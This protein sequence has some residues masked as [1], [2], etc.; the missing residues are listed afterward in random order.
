MSAPKSLLR[1]IGDHPAFA[2][3]E[4][5]PPFERGAS[6]IYTVRLQPGWCVGGMCEQTVFGLTMK[7]VRL[8]FRKLRP[9]V[10]HCRFRDLRHGP[11]CERGG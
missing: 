7:A 10:G 4:M 8:R 2:R 1:I 3:G 9:C 5:E 6:T 11:L